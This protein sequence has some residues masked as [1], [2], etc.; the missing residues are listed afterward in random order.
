MECEVNGFGG[1]SGTTSIV[2]EAYGY[3]LDQRAIY[4]S[5]GGASGAFVVATNSSFGVNNADCNSATY[6]LWNDMYNAM[7][8]YGF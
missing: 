7:G 2:L 5:T 6:S 3:I 1:S 8:E 4:D